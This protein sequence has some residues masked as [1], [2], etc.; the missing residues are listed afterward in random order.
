ML[1]AL[2]ADGAIF[3]GLTRSALEHLLAGDQ[4]VSPA[5]D[6]NGPRFI[7]AFAET[8]EALRAMLEAEGSITPRTRHVDLRPK[9]GR[10]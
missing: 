3:I 1:R 6:G 7:I 2:R 5:F 10:A 4:L 9:R 8:D